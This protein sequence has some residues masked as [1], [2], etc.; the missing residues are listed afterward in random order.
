MLRS[1]KL[2]V[3][4]PA[5]VG[6]GLRNR[7]LRRSRPRSPARPTAMT[8][9]MI[10]TRGPRSRQGRG[11]HHG[12]TRRAGKAMSTTPRSFTMTP[13]RA[14]DGLSARRIGEEGG[15][16]GN[17]TSVTLNVKLDGKPQQF[18]LAAERAWAIPPG[19]VL[20]SC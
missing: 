12:R 13:A 17:A 9:I 4:G 1:I 8:T 3:I 16:D 6:R 10:T 19:R 7:A 14:V 5:V 2:T 15:G 11:P 18:Q 20:S